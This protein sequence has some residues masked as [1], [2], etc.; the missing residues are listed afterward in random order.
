M[1]VS[2]PARAMGGCGI[3]VKGIDSN[4]YSFLHAT[5]KKNILIT[6]IALA[7]ITLF[8]YKWFLSLWIWIS[9]KGKYLFVQILLGGLIMIE[10]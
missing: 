5:A 4:E 9:L 1:V 6:T 10:D 7:E 8:I 3:V 2:I